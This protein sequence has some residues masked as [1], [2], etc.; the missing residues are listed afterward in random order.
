MGKVKEPLPACLVCACMGPPRG[1]WEEVR[2]RLEER[3][4]PVV[5]ESPSYPFDF[6]GY[7][8]GEMGKGLIK[9][10]WAFQPPFPREALV[11]AKLFA[12]ALEEELGE[13]RE[14]RL[15]R[16]VNLDPG[17]LT[18]AQLVLASTKDY[19]HRIY[20]GRGIHGEVTLIYRG[21]GFRPLEWTYPD[22]RT[23]LVLDFLE[24]VRGMLLTWR[25]G[26]GG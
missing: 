18:D 12:N 23:P 21:G 8:E 5:L 17:Y 16:V 22:Y 20:L 13:Y 19:S 2:R 15:H 4:G 3:F 9:F 24:E 7:Y 14:G 26:K 25:R 6:T 11:E 10:I 1:P